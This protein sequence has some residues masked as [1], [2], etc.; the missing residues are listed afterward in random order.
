MID[1]SEQ[2]NK[3]RFKK[4]YKSDFK[5]WTPSKSSLEALAIS[6]QYLQIKSEEE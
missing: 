4:T 1:K 5:P 2:H 3:Q 6:R